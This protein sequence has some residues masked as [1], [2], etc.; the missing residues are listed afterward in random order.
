MGNEGR[1]ARSSGLD[2]GSVVRVGLVELDSSLGLS[3][4]DLSSLDLTIRKASR[5]GRGEGRR[6]KGKR[7]Q[8]E[9][10][11]SKPEL[12]LVLSRTHAGVSPLFFMIVSFPPLAAVTICFSIELLI[13]EDRFFCIVLRT[14]APSFF[15]GI[16]RAPFL[17][18]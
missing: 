13:F 4:V 18:F 10:N 12:L 2:V 8:L 14:T 1:Q 5:K 16:E 9:L 3:L 15:G 11:S 7:G 6:E 17:G